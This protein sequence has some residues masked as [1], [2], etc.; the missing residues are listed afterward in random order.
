MFARIYTHSKQA[1]HSKIARMLLDEEGIPYEVLVIPAME[2]V[3][4]SKGTTP[5]GWIV[6]L[7]GKPGFAVNWKELYRLLEDHNMFRKF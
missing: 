2:M 5:F 1:I 3:M 6:E 4:R 7:D